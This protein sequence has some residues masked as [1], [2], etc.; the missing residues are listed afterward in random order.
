M[1]LK[2]KI[3][4]TMVEIYEMMAKN[5]EDAE[6]RFYEADDLGDYFIESHEAE[7]LPLIIEE[8]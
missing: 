2:F 1:W 6:R 5:K 3:T 7:G 8:V 4:R